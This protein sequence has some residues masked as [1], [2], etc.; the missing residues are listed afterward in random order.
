MKMEYTHFANPNHDV[1]DL[2]YDAVLGS[3]FFAS[4]SFGSVI[5]YERGM[6]LQPIGPEGPTV[7]MHERDKKAR[8][9]AAGSVKFKV[10]GRANEGR[11][12]LH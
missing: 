9:P 11:P 8:L 5:S 2:Q 10:W 12:Q 6:S 3:R 1:A 4:G 7:R